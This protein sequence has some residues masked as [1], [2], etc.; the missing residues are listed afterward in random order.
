V[1]E[2]FGADQIDAKYD[3]TALKMANVGDKRFGIPWVTGTIGLVANG[4][5]M[6][7]AGI[8][9]EPK[10]MDEW[11]KILQDIKR[12]V[13]SSSP[14]G[15][16]TKSAGLA[17]FESQLIF[18]NYGASFIGEDGEIAIDSSEARDALTMLTQMV[19]DGLILPGND[20]FDF[21]NLFA[22]GLVGFYPDL[23][24]AKAFARDLSAEGE[25]YE[26]YVLPVPIPVASEGMKPVSILG[27]HLVV[28]P[29][30][31]GTQPTP[32]SAAGKFIDLI[33]STDVQIE[34]YR[35]TGFFPTTKE[36]IA[37]LKDD[38]FFVNWNKANSNARTDEFAPFLNAD[39]L[40]TIVGEEI[41]AS[42]LGQKSPDEAITTMTERLKAAEP[43]R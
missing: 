30:Y 35:A 2:V 15:F 43:R 37:V 17:Q 19:K 14:F 11:L 31:G 22:Q 9:G 38:Q 7:A 34:Y 28:L 12:A 39:N 24:L 3:A 42:M 33:T 29:E 4:K 5:V 18:W 13:P 1:D 26:E 32:D 40:R 36:A 25:A 21:R 23:P 8:N 41:I 27:G 16:S 6:D 10:T 20:R